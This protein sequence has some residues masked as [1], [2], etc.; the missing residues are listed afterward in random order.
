MLSLIASDQP[1][2]T[3]RLHDL[4]AAHGHDCPQSHVV[5]LDDALEAT[6]HV[7]R[8]LELVLAVIG[9]PLDRSLATLEQL[10]GR[11][12]AV[13]VAVGS[14][15]D[16]KQILRVIRAGADDYLDKDD[17]LAGQL[18]AALSRR[19]SPAG[20]STRPCRV[21]SVVSASGGCGASTLVANLGVVLAKE[22]GRCGLVDLSLL[23]GD[24]AALLSLKPRHTVADLCRTIEKLDQHMFEQSLVKHDSGVELLPAPLAPSEAP[25]VTAD[26]IHQILQVGRRIFRYLVVDLCDLFHKEQRAAVELSDVV[27]LV[28]RLD[29]TAIRNARKALNVLEEAEIPSNRICLIANRYRQPSEVPAPRAQSA[30]GFR[31][32]HYIPDA[33][34]AV[35]MSI[36]CGVPVVLE[37]PGAKVSKSLTTLARSLNGYPDANGSTE[38]VA[39]APSPSSDGQSRKEAPKRWLEFLRPKPVR[40]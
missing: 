27:V 29:F 25:C 39:A 13:I 40:G 22:Y 21:I 16:P 35:N 3:A 28:C 24:L 38:D 9:D 31:I 4:L 32:S 1:A 10:R 17:D 23:R 18:Q 36:N 5:T 30:L 12:Q 19:V 20:A 14:A 34:K 2:L 11:T 6:A 8:Q 33:T 37:A 7:H 15:R 26:A